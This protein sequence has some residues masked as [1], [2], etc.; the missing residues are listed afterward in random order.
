MAEPD[1]DAEAET[2]D[3]PEAAPAEEEE[4]L[5]AGATPGVNEKDLWVRNS[6]LAADHVAAGSFETAMQVWNNTYFLS[7]VEVN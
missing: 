7:G 6:P 1:A 5:G 3:T 4:E 2:F